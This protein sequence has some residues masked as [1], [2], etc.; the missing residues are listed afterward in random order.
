MIVRHNFPTGDVASHQAGFERSLRD[1]EALPRNDLPL[2][3]TAL[4]DALVSVLGAWLLATDQDD[5]SDFG[6]RVGESLRRH[7]REIGSFQGNLYTSIWEHT[8]EG[9][10]RACLSRSCVEIVDT[11]VT[12]PPFGADWLAEINREM[13]ANGADLPPLPAAVVPRAIPASHWWWSLP[14]GPVHDE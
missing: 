8:P 11:M 13:R 6:G 12:P 10:Y 4:T 14:A 2:R 3:T 5:L 7:D 9:W 1:L